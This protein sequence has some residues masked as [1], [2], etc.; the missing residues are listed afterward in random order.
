MDHGEGNRIR[1]SRM[2]LQR[3]ALMA[4]CEA[5]AGALAQLAVVGA[6]TSTN[7]AVAEA[8]RADDAGWPHVS[9][10][11]ADHQTAGRGRAGRDW[12]TPQGA[13]LTVS[14]VL[15]PQ[16]VARSAYGWVPLVV[17]LAATRALADVG[18][19]ARLKW[20]NDVVVEA[21]GDAV[22][23]W[24]GAR[25]VA[26]ILCEVVG[27]A[28]VAGI[29]INVSQSRDE[30]PVP[31][32]TSLALAGATSLDRGELLAHMSRRL[33]EAVDAWTGAD[34]GATHAEVEAA[35]ATIGQAVVV[36][37]PSG[38]PVTGTAVRLGPDGALVVATSKGDISVVAGDVRV[39]ASA[40]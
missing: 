3:T 13:A 1:D 15:R 17:G 29:G 27:S 38:P 39:R 34:D 6:S 2:P 23:G 35:C 18:V 25:K 33:V 11:V 20:P 32:A 31:H 10:L 8:L 22:P 30:L 5:P 19:R 14:F 37:V 7:T 24:G 12:F 28:V 36:E 26:G 16:G 21:D 9:A 4:R 40:Q